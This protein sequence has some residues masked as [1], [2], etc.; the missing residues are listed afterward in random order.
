MAHQNIILDGIDHGAPERSGS[1]FCNEGKWDNFIKPL[2]PKECSEMTFVEYGSNAGLFLRLA[3]EYS[4][5]NVVGVE[6]DKRDCELSKK[7]LDSFNIDHRII[8]AQMSP[9]F[10]FKLLP[11]ADVTLLANFHYHQSIGEFLHILDKLETKSCYVIV[12]SVKDVFKG[13]HWRAQPNE[14]DIMVYFKNWEFIKTIKDIPSDGDVHPREMFSMLFKS[15]KIKRVPSD[16]LSSGEEHESVRSRKLNFIKDVISGKCQ[17][18]TIS[19]I[20][21]NGI[22]EPVII[23]RDGVLVDG[24]HR[25]SINNLKHK[26]IIART[27]HE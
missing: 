15:S 6:R 7:Y 20:F 26:T 21:T 1:R 11:L 27:F 4:F 3:K 14:E 13:R 10:D 17:D 24:Y 19:D 12:V 18:E 25:L 9:D 16:V 8:E 22:C 2:L 23:N 5:Y